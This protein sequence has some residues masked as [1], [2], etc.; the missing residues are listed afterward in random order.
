MKDLFELLCSQDGEYK[1]FFHRMFV[2]GNFYTVNK[3]QPFLANRLIYESGY[4]HII[5]GI[6]YSAVIYKYGNIAIMKLDDD[7]DAISFDFSGCYMA[8][9]TLGHQKYVAHIAKEGSPYAAVKEW[10]S[11][12]ESRLIGNAIL[13]K[14]SEY[15][16]IRLNGIWGIIT[17][18]GDC[19]SI[20]TYEDQNN[21]KCYLPP[22]GISRACPLLG[23]NA[24]IPL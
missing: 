20:M 5:D 10:N 7:S 18:R 8:V 21:R 1:L 15:F 4:Q 24:I 19:Y 13:F 11:L 6:K 3:L 22:D 14:P 23:R 16:P 2:C 12:V 9:F 17:S